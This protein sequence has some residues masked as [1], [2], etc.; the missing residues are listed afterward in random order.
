MLPTPILGKR[1]VPNY[2]QEFEHASTPSKIP[3][4]E[5][6]L[7]DEQNE[8]LLQDIKLNLDKI[9]N[10]YKEM[11]NEITGSN[12]VTLNN[13]IVMLTT[14]QEILNDTYDIVQN[15]KETLDELENVPFVPKPTRY[16]SETV[17]LLNRLLNRLSKNKVGGAKT[18]PRHFTVTHCSLGKPGGRYNGTGPASAAK[19]AASIRFAAT[20]GTKSMRLSIRE[21]GTDR[22][23][24]YIANRIQISKHGGNKQEKIEVKSQKA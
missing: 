15:A 20:T 22:V 1:P 13:Y 23:R 10:Y 5:Q 16:V 9:I 17:L 12:K 3:T 19:R 24:H 21:I 7:Q 4:N 2:R 14:E 11:S 8:Q 6:L 18:T